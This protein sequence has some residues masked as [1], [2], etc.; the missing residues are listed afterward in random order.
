MVVDNVEKLK[1]LGLSV[2][3]AKTYLSLLKNPNKTA[4]SIAKTTNIHRANVY[5]ALNSLVAKALAYKVIINN[6]HLYT[7]AKP[8]K[9]K[10]IMKER[11]LIVENLIPELEVSKETIQQVSV[12]KG[13]DAFFELL[14]ELL[15]QNEPIYVFDIPKYVPQLVKNHITAFHKERAKR[16]IWMHHIYDYNAG[17]RITMLNK[18]PFTTAIKGPTHRQSLV[19]T[20]VCGDTTLI[21]NWRKGMKVVKIIDQDV[22]ETYR[23]QYEV[24]KK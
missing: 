6:K 11:S 9:L 13:I 20:L 14:Y 18:L 15:E 3:E 1:L 21:V 19:S 5:D 8:A 17:K 12:Y 23:M 24:L 2:V 4:Y 10:Q 22:A 7:A 16:K